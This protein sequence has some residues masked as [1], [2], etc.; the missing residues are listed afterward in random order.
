MDNLDIFQAIAQ[1]GG[2]VILAGA[3]LTG[4]VMTKAGVDAILRERDKADLVRD[5]RL[6]D[7]KQINKDLT[8]ALKVN[9]DALRRLADAWEARNRAEA[10]QGGR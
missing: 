7:Q 3:L 5:E 9:A 10:D 2:L 8:E 1:L 4:V 6:A